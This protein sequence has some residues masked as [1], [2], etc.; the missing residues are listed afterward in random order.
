MIRP[1]AARFPDA[2]FPPAPAVERFFCGAARSVVPGRGA[3]LRAGP[4]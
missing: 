1:E 4:V 3:G 2:P